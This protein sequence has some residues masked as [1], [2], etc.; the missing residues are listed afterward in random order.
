MR[1]VRDRPLVR[2]FLD[3]EGRVVS[4]P[5]RRAA[6]LDV[7]HYLA[8]RLDSEVGYSEREITAIIEAAH[9]FGDAALLR[10]EL[11]EHGLVG[12]TRDGWRYWLSRAE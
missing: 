11:F 2:R 12:R 10:R 3:D 9:T 6:R 5:A 8:D 7:L 4:W 1:E